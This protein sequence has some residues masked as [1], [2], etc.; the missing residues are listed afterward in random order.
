MSIR[1]ACEHCGKKY[2]LA[3]EHAG[4]KV[5]CKQCGQ[6]G[7][8]P[9]VEAQTELFNLQTLLEAAQGPAVETV[10]PPRL[11]PAKSIPQSRIRRDLMPW[12][13]RFAVVATVLIVVSL[14]ATGGYVAWKKLIAKP[15]LV[16][17]VA[18]EVNLVGCPLPKKKQADLVMDII[19]NLQEPAKT[20]YGKTVKPSDAYCLRTTIQQ[21]G[22]NST[23]YTTIIAGRSRPEDIKS[24][25][26]P[27]MLVTLSLFDTGGR[28]LSSTSFRHVPKIDSFFQ[29][30]LTEDNQS[31]E[32]ALVWQAWEHVKLYLPAI[33]PL[34]PGYTPTPTVAEPPFTPPS[35]TVDVKLVDCPLD[36]WNKKR[37]T[38]L[39]VTN[40]GNKA[41]EKY[42]RLAK[43]VC[44]RA[45]FEK[46]GTHTLEYSDHGATH[47]SELPV[48]AI[49]LSVLDGSGRELAKSGTTY[50]ERIGMIKQIEMQENQSVD[51]ALVWNTWLNARMYLPPLPTVAPQPT[52]RR[53]PKK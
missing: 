16:P 33:P 42:S 49:T 45:T 14:L 27:V 52:T 24:V 10:P 5:R 39:L 17:G 1:F 36:K 29:M 46:K 4:K 53:A 35:V 7:Q 2:I 30:V 48:L 31:M 20:A 47:R 32:E 50:K 12:V 6:I 13:R 41:E 9:A 44:L 40:L 11:A 28:E 34:E 8:I 26:L 21:N 15:M 3:D 51:E 25:D 43:S 18:V 22:V 23:E 38:D 19:K 37:L